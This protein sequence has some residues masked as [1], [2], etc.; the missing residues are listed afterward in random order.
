MHG[1]DKVKVV[2]V[3]DNDLAQFAKRAFGEIDIERAAYEAGISRASFYNVLAGK[4]V[5][6]ETLERVAY[7]A[8][9]APEERGLIYAGLMYYSG[10]LDAMP[11]GVRALVEGL[12]AHRGW[13]LSRSNSAYGI[14]EHK[15]TTGHERATWNLDRELEA[16]FRRLYPDAAE[17]IDKMLD[18]RDARAGDETAPPH[19]NSERRAS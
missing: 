11:Q 6:A 4:S 16:E 1:G 12:L 2:G 10:L 14:S 5:R 7:G 17:V 19:S 3:S 9:E 18:E 15:R 13:L 8:G